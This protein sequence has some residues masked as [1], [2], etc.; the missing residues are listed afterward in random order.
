MN[1]HI[2]P[3]RLADAELIAACNAAIAAESEQLQLDPDRLLQGVR[4]VLQNPDRGFYT[5]AEV[6]G[7]VVG[8]VLVTLEWSDWRNGVFWW[9]QSVY[10]RPD[11]RRRGIFQSLY[12]HLLEQAQSLGTV[13]G[14]RL[15]VDR[16]NRIAQSV[17]ERAGMRKTQYDLYEVDFIL[18][19]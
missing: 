8:Q 4:A 6:D 3:A 12:R 11:V 14:L 18:K 7:A 1:I 16:Q 15:Y 10:V 5:L 13:C 9:L 17:Y 2:R 19:R